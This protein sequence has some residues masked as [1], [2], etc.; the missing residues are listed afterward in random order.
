MC[1]TFQLSVQEREEVWDLP[2]IYKCLTILAEL[3]RKADV[4]KASIGLADVMEN[5]VLKCL[6]VSYTFLCNINLNLLLFC[7]NV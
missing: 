6:A 2:V 5:F 1:T 4:F 3:M 7:I